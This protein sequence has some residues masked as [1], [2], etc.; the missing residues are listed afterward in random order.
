[1]RVA[2]AKPD[3]GIVG[4]FE[5]VL[6]RIAV[7][8]EARGH[9]VS[10]LL[11]DVPSLGRSP[12]HADVPDHVW[13]AQPEFFRYAALV[14]AF[15]K[16]DT[17]GHDMVVSTQP[18]SFALDHPRHLC[19]FFH[20][21]RIYYDL[22]DVYLAAGLADDPELHHAAARRVREMDDQFL[23]RPQWVLAGSEVVKERLQSFNHLADVGLFHAGAGVPPGATELP[24]SYDGPPLC[25]SRH[26]FP[27]RTE[28]FVH[29]IKLLP[30]IDG[31]IV[32]GGGRLDFVRNLDHRLSQPDADLDA[33]SPH[34]LWLC[35]HD[36][37]EPVPQPGSARARAG[38]VR[39]LG[40]VSDGELARLYANACCVV[41]PAYLE[42]YGLTAIEAMHYGKPLV[43]CRDGGGLTAFVEDGVN[44]LV[45]DPTGPAI[46]EAVR[47]LK[48]DPDLA[49]R[50]G[51]AGRE[52]ARRYTWDRAMA[53]IEAGMDR[54]MA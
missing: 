51:Q 34:D 53:E 41:A 6:R 43:V 20:H 29:A 44:G 2:I 28:L 39:F 38:N 18:P 1:M 19:V 33:L 47:T 12:F 48:E 46:A 36:N 26:E 22:S 31:D 13:K 14:D 11:V 16:L 8:L 24:S 23:R 21:V 52:T 45:V 40:H 49:R 50:L 42:D 25:V 10:W 37:F 3:Y 15:A 32:G 9:D 54:V 5:L 4:G 35:R 27:K 30:G 17:R 7:E